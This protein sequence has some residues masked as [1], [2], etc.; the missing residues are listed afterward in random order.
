MT[1]PSG[2]I[3]LN[4]IAVSARIVWPVAFILV[5]ILV[6]SFS[7]L[8]WTGSGPTAQPSCARWTS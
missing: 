6:I 3:R 1:M 5:S 2:S 7:V 4:Q 8:G